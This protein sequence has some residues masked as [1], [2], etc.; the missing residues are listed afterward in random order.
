[1]VMF[2]SIGLIHI[3]LVVR[4]LRGGG[5]AAT[6]VAQPAACAGAGGAGLWADQPHQP[7]ASASRASAP[8]RSLAALHPGSVFAGRR[9]AG[10]NAFGG[11][12]SRRRLY[13]GF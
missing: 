6:W 3:V 10:C 7:L 11:H 5:G 2:G 1:M 4:S 8:S 12:A 13:P 9:D